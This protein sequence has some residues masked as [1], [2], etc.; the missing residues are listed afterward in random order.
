[1]KQTKLVVLLAM[2]VIVMSVG[3]Y[4]LVAA[5]EGSK[6]IKSEEVVNRAAQSA[7]GG[8]TVEPAGGG[9]TSD[10]ASGKPRRNLTYRASRPFT[11]VPPAPAMEYVQ[12]GVT[13]WRLQKAEGAKQMDQEGEEAKLEQLEASTQLSIGSMVRLGIE[14]LTRDGF[15]YVIDREQFADGG[16]GEA[17][18]IFPTLRTRNGNNSVRAHELV[19][20]PR[21]PSYFLI[22]PSNTGRAQSAEVLT[23]IVSPTPL[24]LPA[25][26]GERAMTI[27]EQLFKSWETQW[28]P[29]SVNVLEMNG[30]AGTT[31][32]VKAQ[33]EGAK[34]LD[35]QGQERQQLT[36][37]DALPQ[38]IYRAAIRK[39][40]ALLVTVP[41]KFKTRQ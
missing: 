4:H 16:Y 22:N 2:C 3:P 14:P 15:L 40:R 5:Q 31:S 30:G 34:S 20:I 36:Q 17:Q 25:A 18:L 12:V 35:Q 6:D 23:I 19:L 1:M 41:L 8:A 26:L 13:I 32:S 27:S 39:D 7:G 24:Q 28:K 37:G 21:P 29:A 9:S 33:A 38:T 10:K 11:K